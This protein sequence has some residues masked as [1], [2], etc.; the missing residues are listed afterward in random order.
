MI[1]FTIFQRNLLLFLTRVLCFVII[2][3]TYAS[4]IFMNSFRWLRSP[5][6]L[7]YDPALRKTLH[8]LMKK[9]FIQLVAEFKRLGAIIIFANFN[10]IIICTKKKSV[11]DAISY[12]EYVVQNIRNTELFHSIEISYN[13]CW[14]YLMWLD[15]A[16]HGGVRGKLP[17]G[18]NAA[19]EEENK[20]SLSNMDE[21]NERAP[22][23][24]QS[25]LGEDDDDD[26]V[27]IFKLKTHLNYLSFKS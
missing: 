17:T 26:G 10:K 6:A 2:I 23:D 15:L 19:G 5:N 14:E 24:D 20:I 22:Q 18:L 1:F 21:N 9:L 8:N 27:R 3:I 25:E 7:L 16:N 13:Q 4:Q 11:T 12:V